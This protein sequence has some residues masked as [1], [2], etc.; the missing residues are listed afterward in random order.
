MKKRHKIRQLTF[1]TVLSCI[2]GIPLSLKAQNNK[3]Q[4]PNPIGP[5]PEAASIVK[6]VDMTINE[7]KGMVQKQIPIYQIEEGS[8]RLPVSLLYASGGFKVT[9]ASSSVGLGWSLQAAG[10]VTRTMN[11]LPDDISSPVKGFLALKNE[12]DYN[13]LSHGDKNQTRYGYLQSIGQG[14]YDAQPDIFN[15]NFNGYTGKFHFDWNGNIII[16]SETQIAITPIQHGGNASTITGWIFTTP[17]GVRYTFKAAEFTANI[18]SG[19]NLCY[20]AQD[21]Y[22]SSWYIS[23]ITAPVSNANLFFEYTPYTIKDHNIYTS[24]TRSHLVGGSSRCGGSINDPIQYSKTD[25]DINGKALKRIYSDS[26]PVEI[27]FIPASYKVMPTSNDLFAISEI[28]IKN[29]DQNK[30][31]KKYK[32]THSQA[33]GRLTL[34]RLQ[35][36]GSNLEGLAPYEFFYHQQLPERSSHQKDHWGFANN[37]TSRDMLPPYFI[38]VPGNGVA[39]FG[40]ADR[41]ADLEGSKKGVLYKIKYPTGGYDT[42]SFEQNTYGYVGGNRINEFVSQKHTEKVTATGNSGQGCTAINTDTDR[43]SFTITGDPN[44]PDK[45]VMV[46]V[47]GK[48]DK[49]TDNYFSGGKAPK[50]TL[51]NS[52]NNVLLTI[53]LTNNDIDKGILLAPGSYSLVAEATWRNCENTSRDSATITLIHH[54]VTNIPLYEKKAGGVRVASIKKYDA[55]NKLLLSQQYQYKDAQ[56]YSSGMIHQEPNYLFEKQTLQWVGTGGG[57]TNVSCQYMVALDTDRSALG[58]TNGSHIG[59]SKVSSIQKGEDN[60]QTP[61][62]VVSTTFIN[63]TNIIDQ[64]FPFPPPIDR[65]HSNGKV[66]TSVTSNRNGE[67]LQQQEHSYQFKEH[68]TNALKVD[69]KGGAVLGEEN[70]TIGRYRI[71]MAHSQ[72]KKA[73]T[74]EYLKGE[75]Y[76]V[77]SEFTYN[78]ALQK[79]K[80]KTTYNQQQTKRQRFFYPEEYTSLTGLSQEEKT[81]YQDLIDQYRLATPIQNE[82]YTITNNQSEKLTAIQRIRY[83]NDGKALPKTILQAKNNKTALEDRLYYHT[84][85][86]KGNL[87]ELSK[88]LAS[89]IVY[90]Y[91]Y[92]DQLPVAKIENA[93]YSQVRTYVAAIKTAS[94]A[95]TDHCSEPDCKE[96]LLRNKLNALRDQLPDALITT[97]TYDPMIGV[98]STTDPKG[99][100]TYYSYDSLGRLHS[101]KD[102]DGNLISENK[103]HYKNQ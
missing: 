8:I 81:A 24:R 7:H 65:A 77:T 82:V 68:L 37:N 18:K 38:Q 25:I 73:E 35:E 96:Q 95:D 10:V 2:I 54:K 87:L 36:I 79:V 21:G 4:I 100:T 101:I 85:D 91:G 90:I 19:R 3:V 44:S 74:T 99:I 28:Q 39:S 89:H 42:Y 6:Y 59:Y 52:Q 103:Y 31:I 64:E 62:G 88:P 72:R 32:L 20:L 57:G 70:F 94:N 49:Y 30:L 93:T 56:G 5:S 13:Y 16:S 43:T 23:Q 66:I 17:D 9:E 84:Y 29:R 97:Y 98:T 27:S 78:T 76:T 48:V 51:Y 67:T 33:T 45:P 34:T 55:N 40:S 86:S 61:N 12:V 15:F 1:I 50:A 41:S 26:S 46:R 80:S 11:G 75:P 60:H 83:T 69:F 14:C 71:L 102:A 53:S 22:I 92:Q 63:A 47:F 58:I